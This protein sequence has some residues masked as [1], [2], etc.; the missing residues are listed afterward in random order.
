MNDTQRSALDAAMTQRPLVAILRGVE[1]NEVDAVF[2]A[3]VEVGFRMIEIPLNS[4]DPWRSLERI[5]ARCPDNVVIG[6]GT[7]LDPAACRRLAALNAS[8]VVTP[9]TDPAVIGE[10]VAQSLAPFIGCMTPTEALTAVRA[11]AHAL[12][13]Y[14]AARLGIDYFRDTRAIL[15]A[16][17]PVL[18][19]G[20]IELSNME[21]WRAAGIDGFGFGGS[22][23]KPR[24]APADIAH[25]GRDLIAE[26]QRSGGGPHAPGAGVTAT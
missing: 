7:V 8:L 3:L 20:G 5:T 25:R 14:P 10:A 24:R 1:P 12:K 18:A 9:N 15:P 11:G 23:Y 2:D 4:P 6:A 13:L 17:M 19:V 22:L 21:E 26:W 16:S